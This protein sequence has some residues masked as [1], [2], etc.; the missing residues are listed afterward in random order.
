MPMSAFAY[1]TQTISDSC[2][3]FWRN[4]LYAVFTPNQY[5]CSSGQFLPANTLG[6]ASC[7]SDYT[8]AGGTF[9][10]NAEE[11]QGLP[12]SPN[13]LY[14]HNL[15]N[16]CAKNA[17][18]LMDAIF[19]PNTHTCSAGYYLPA[20]IDACTLCPTGGNCSGGTFTFNE[21]TNQGVDSCDSGYYKD[22]GTCIANTITVRWDDGNGGAYTTTCT[23]GG[24]LYTPSTPPVAPKGYHFTG[25]SFNLGN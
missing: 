3:V 20:G 14:T 15:T 10:F 17:P 25:W 23:Y 9:D 6:C 1:Y 13:D 21:T 24:T 16:A 5:T 22:N 2:G 11:N 7:P 4:E 8:C 18:H 12:H 19:I